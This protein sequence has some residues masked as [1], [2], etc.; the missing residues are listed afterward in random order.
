MSKDNR[1]SKQAVSI[2]GTTLLCTPPST[3][4]KFAFQA[5]DRNQ[6]GENLFFA[7]SIFAKNGK[8]KKSKILHF[9]AVF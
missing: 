4:V 9:L 7:S 2:G 5:N 1:I 3:E 8:N 6:L